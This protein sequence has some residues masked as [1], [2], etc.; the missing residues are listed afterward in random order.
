MKITTLTLTD[1][2]ATKQLGLFLAKQLMVGD[3]LALKG[4]LGA[5]KSELA[6][7]IIRQMCPDETDI[8]SPTFTLVQAYESDDNGSL[9]HFDLYRL[10]EPGDVFELG[11][12][13]AFA[14]A[15][16]LIEWPERLAGYLP[17]HAL[18]IAIDYDPGRNGDREVTL[19]GDAAWQKRLKGILPD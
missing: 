3:V 13:D 1:P 15:I 6:R 11:I 2:A 5:G 10:T 9:L 8:P 4:T 18:T 7:A 14:E 19:S 16:C 17:D 12:E